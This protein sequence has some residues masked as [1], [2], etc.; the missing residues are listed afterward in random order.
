M[1]LQS[2]LKRMSGGMEQDKHMG[3]NE[4]LNF[5]ASYT[6]FVTSFFVNVPKKNW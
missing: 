5:L 4:P 1:I 6:F 2:R 3:L